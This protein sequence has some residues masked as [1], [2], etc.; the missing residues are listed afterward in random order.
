MPGL[1]I[2][3]MRKGNCRSTT[4]H[5]ITKGTVIIVVAGFRAVTRHLVDLPSQLRLDLATY[6]SLFIKFE[7]IVRYNPRLSNYINAVYQSKTET[8][9]RYNPILFDYSILRTE[10]ATLVILT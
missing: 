4:C 2:Q 8:I 1:T 6:G 10:T 5:F 7:A 9:T 3:H